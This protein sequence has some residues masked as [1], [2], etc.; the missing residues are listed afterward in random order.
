M[1]MSLAAQDTWIDCMGNQL[2]FVE[3]QV[4]RDAL[5]ANMLPDF[6]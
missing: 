5:L 2:T 3:S 6:Q 4:P 1:W